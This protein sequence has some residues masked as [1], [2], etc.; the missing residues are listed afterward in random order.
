MKVKLKKFQE[1]QFELFKKGVPSEVTFHC[2]GFSMISIHRATGYQHHF[3]TST[4]HEE[5][6]ELIKQA[7]EA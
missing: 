7:K 6:N 2:D 4:T 5:L 3:S 1:L